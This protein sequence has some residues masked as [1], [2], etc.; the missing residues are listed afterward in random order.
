MTVQKPT[1]RR[2]TATINAASSSQSSVI[3]TPS[4]VAAARSCKHAENDAV[5]LEQLDRLQ[6]GRAQ[7]HEIAWSPHNCIAHASSTSSFVT[8]AVPHVVLRTIG[9][10]AKLPSGSTSRLTKYPQTRPCLLFP[11]PDVISAIPPGTSPPADHPA[12]LYDDPQSISFSPCGYYL[13]AFFPIRQSNFVRASQHATTNA[14]AVTA[15]AASTTLNGAPLTSV[16]TDPSGAPV[17]AA[18]GST[19]VPVSIPMMNQLSSSSSGGAAGTL[20]NP[21]Q[22]L[23]VDESAAPARPDLQTAD[24][25]LCIWSR[26]EEGTH[27]AWKLIQSV[28]VREG[29][30]RH[31]GARRK[32]DNVVKVNEHGE[33]VVS[34]ARDAESDQTKGRKR[35]QGGVARVQ[36]L[37]QRRST[38]LAQPTPSPAASLTTPSG[39]ATARAF[40]RL[41]PRGP[42]F[43]PSSLSASRGPDRDVAL[44]VFGKQGQVSLLYSRHADRQSASAEAAAAPATSAANAGQ[45]AGSTANAAT[46]ATTARQLPDFFRIL[47]SSLY[48]P[49]LQPAPVTLDSGVYSSPGTN[50]DASGRDMGSYTSLFGHDDVDITHLAIGML[51]N[52]GIMLAASKRGART[53][54]LL[55]LSEITVDLT[56]ET[57]SMITRPISTLPIPIAER[58]ETA[59]TEGLDGADGQTSTDMHANVPLLTTLVWAEPEDAEGPTQ[60]AQDSRRLSSLKLVACLSAANDSGSSSASDENATNT[61]DG[62]DGDHSTSSNDRTSS[63]TVSTTLLVWDVQ[64]SEV[65]LSDAFASLECRKTGH[66]PKWLDWH[67]TLSSSTVLSDKLVTSLTANATRLPTRDLGLLTALVPSTAKSAETGGSS[68]AGSDPV[69][70]ERSFYLDLKTVELVDA[71]ST[72][73]LIPAHAMCRSC[74]PV[75]SPNGVLVASLSQVPAGSHVRK[76]VIWKLDVPPALLATGNSSNGAATVVSTGS[77]GT[78]A[79]S[80]FAKLMALSSVRMTDPADLVRAF[81]PLDASMCSQALVEIGE[82]LR[83][84]RSSSSSSSGPSRRSADGIVKLEPGHST[85]GAPAT[86][87]SSVGGS[88]SFAHV[89]ELL[90]LRMA[91]GPAEKGSGATST[92]QAQARPERLVMELA[93][94]YQVLRLSRVKTD[95]TSP[96]AAD[97]ASSEERKKSSSAAAGKAAGRVYYRLDGVWSILEKMQWLLQL[98]DRVAR[99]AMQSQSKSASR[100][101]GAPPAEAKAEAEEAEDAYASGLI[102]MLTMAA[103][104]RLVLETLSLVCDFKD[105]LLSTVKRENLPAALS[106]G[107]GNGNGIGSV[108]GRDPMG[109]IFTGPTFDAGVVAVSEQMELARDA[110]RHILV[111][112]AIDVDAFTGVL[113]GLDEETVATTTA[114]QADDRTTSPT[115]SSSSSYWWNQLDPTSTD[116]TTKPN[117]TKGQANSESGS[118]Q[119]TRSKL[120][121]SITD[122]ESGALVDVLTLFLSPSDLVD[123]RSVLYD[124]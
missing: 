60:N 122:P 42:A 100:S 34:F 71:H 16:A 106:T 92:S 65:E 75:I 5:V 123:E 68:T 11:T 57:V 104:R 112:S 113:R 89:L 99:L 47:Q 4:Q 108:S 53:D 94:C 29:S 59:K 2:R 44:I 109:G 107:N 3:L 38:V 84:I 14:A 103:P 45:N 121:A 43:P 18:A 102:Q 70:V 76:P 115:K 46:S 37:N 91:M 30:G 52:S 62:Q 35:L 31:P 28:A 39:S 48:V 41:A 111:S 82:L 12:V 8:P 36:W 33:R 118:S 56:N 22:K 83:M 79:A 117:T 95:P 19:P 105:W 72:E 25:R 124:A 93:L 97:T 120:F 1:K 9:P 81:A 78:E 64:R 114:G 101:A 32:P 67:L 21:L 77:Q 24:G 50:E 23:A 63:A 58:D 66:A 86:S 69:L 74:S 96:A 88:V 40:A 55:D 13:C 90:Q 6:A 10:K 73:G 26:A 7:H 20:A 51:P 110:L 54:A 85:T 80:R 15:A 27:D 17:A 61:H 49:E 119:T 116:L 98:L 87:S